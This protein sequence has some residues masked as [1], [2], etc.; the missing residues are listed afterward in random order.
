MQALRL[1]HVVD[2]HWK[3]AAV[4]RN[5]LLGSLLPGG[6]GSL[7]LSVDLNEWFRMALHAAVWRRTW[8]RIAA[9]HMFYTEYILRKTQ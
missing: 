7:P 1:P 5:R 2:F 8:I 9:A 4:E 3:K 6:L